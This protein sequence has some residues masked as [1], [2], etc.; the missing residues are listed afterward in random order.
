MTTFPDSNS[1]HAQIKNENSNPS[2]NSGLAILVARTLARIPTLIQRC[3]IGKCATLEDFVDL[4]YDGPL[5]YIGCSIAP[6]QIREEIVELLQLVSKKQINTMLEIGTAS[7][8]TLFLFA[9]VIKPDAKIISLDLPSGRFGGAYK[10]FRFSVV[11]NSIREKQCMH[12][13]IFWL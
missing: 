12:A 11:V 5:K 13:C 10:D 1:K 6:Q 3:N 8:G 2:R 9:Q 4:C 7:G